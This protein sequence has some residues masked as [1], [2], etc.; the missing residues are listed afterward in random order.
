[1]YPA[2][3]C[4][5][6]QESPEEWDMEVVKAAVNLLGDLCS[7]M[8]HVAPLLKSHPRQQWNAVVTYCSEQSSMNDD[9]EWAINLIKHAYGN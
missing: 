8:S 5:P 4:P 2:P 1:M 6:G 9:T 3:C 7:V